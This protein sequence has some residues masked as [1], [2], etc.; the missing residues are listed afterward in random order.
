MSPTTHDNI[1]TGVSEL[2]DRQAQAFT[3]AA[4]EWDGAPAATVVELREHRARR[5]RTG[6]LAAISVAAIAAAVLAIVGVGGNTTHVR[7][8]APVQ[9]QPGGTAPQGAPVHFHTAKVDLTATDF[10]IHTNGKVFTT[11]DAKVDLHSD[12][13]DPTYWTL[14]LGWNEQGIQMLMNFYFASDGHNW[15]VSEIRTYNGKPEGDWIEYMGNRFTTA[16]GAAFTGDV[17][18]TPSDHTAGTSVHMSGLRITTNPQ[19]FDCSSATG[20]YTLALDYAG[21]FNAAPGTTLMDG[22]ATVLDTKTCAT[23]ADPTRYSVSWTTT[24]ASVLTIARADCAQLVDP[25]ACERGDFFA[26]KGGHAGHTTVHG[27]IHDSKTG[28]VVGTRD[29]PAIV[30]SQSGN[31]PPGPGPVVTIP[32]QPG[33]KNPNVVQVVPGP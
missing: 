29:F 15:W 13:G 18:L 1:Q 16:L 21:T 9:H 4:R 19:R 11:K 3:V 2:F 31:V 26:V 17:D 25:P 27:T 32:V 5:M 14:E 6:G 7:T 20:A 23:P 22:H 33:V 24:D 8:N 10:A 12:P 30:A 28:T